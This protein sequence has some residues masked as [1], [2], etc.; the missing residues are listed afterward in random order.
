MLAFRRGSGVLCVVNYGDGSV[1][2]PTGEVLVASLPGI[3]TTLPHDA[4]VWLRPA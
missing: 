4:A 3:G 1:A 2:L